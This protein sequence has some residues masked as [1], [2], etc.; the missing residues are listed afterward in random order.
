MEN[1]K[2]MIISYLDN[3]RHNIPAEEQKALLE[4]Y[5][6]EKSIKIDLFLQGTDIQ[7]ILF[8]IQTTGHTLLISNI[9]VLGDSL[10][11]IAETLVKLKEKEMT[12][13]DIRDNLTL[14]PAKMN[15]DFIK[16]MF[17]AAEIRSLL[18]SAATKRVLHEK[19]ANGQKL[20]RAFGV[21]NKSSIATKYGDFIS[22]AHANGMSMAEISRQL[23][24]SYRTVF[25]YLKE[26][27]S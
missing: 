13:V 20:G 2:S 12:L 4:A 5:M 27:E 16:G 24:I 10:K 17:L 26:Q 1:K 6:S 14:A 15:D 25:N 22:N 7:T 23:H 3:S 9:L 18:T 11:R 8:S 21:R 19:R